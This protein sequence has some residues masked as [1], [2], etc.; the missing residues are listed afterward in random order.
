[1]L[2]PL[3]LICQSFASF[4]HVFSIDFGSSNT[5]VSTYYN[6]KVKIL[7]NENGN[8]LTPSLVAYDKND[9]IIGEN[10]QNQMILRPDKVVFSLKQF[11]GRTY[12]DTNIKNYI[13]NYPVQII[14]KDNIP[15]FDFQ[16]KYNYND[17]YKPDKLVAMIFTKMKEI[18]YQNSKTK[19]DNAVITIPSYFNE[20]QCN[21]IKKAA[22]KANIKIADIITEQEAAIL[23]YGL[24]K[25]NDTN[26][27]IIIFHLGGYTCEVSLFT[28]ENST[29]NLIE[30]QNDI[31]LGG[32]YF[33]NNIVDYLLDSFSNCTG[34]DASKDVRAIFKLKSGVEKIKHE[35]SMINKTKL[36]IEDFYDGENLIEKM[37]RNDFENINEHLFQK[38]QI[39]IKNVLKKSNCT[40]NDIDEIV[41]IGGSTKIPKVQQIISDCFKGKK[42]FK[43]INPDQV[44]AYGAGLYSTVISINSNPFKSIQI[45]PFSLF[46]DINGKIKSKI[47]PKFCSF[48]IKVTKTILFSNDNHDYLNI[49]VYVEHKEMYERNYNFLIGKFKLKATKNDTN[50]IIITFDL[51]QDYILNVTA[52]NKI[53]NK[54]IIIDNKDKSFNNFI[55]YIR[56][57]KIR[58]KDIINTLNKVG[59]E[60]KMLDMS[61]QKAL[62]WLNI[63]INENVILYDKFKND[64][65][66]HFKN[67]I[68]K[69]I[70]KA[71]YHYYW[72]DDIENPI[73][74]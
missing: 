4:S 14:D 22:K 13:N 45:N 41:L 27:K 2:I 25:N 19:M 24:N 40:Y 32:F 73:I 53:D 30:T 65:E 59:N 18:V 57:A 58:Y 15:H 49:S 54:A 9:F 64:I 11:L 26:K 20:D 44:V 7:E 37:T 21:A 66:Y 69:K 3:S 62:K 70:K 17:W 36:I 42:I 48:P 35:L 51:N 72:E 29:I 50:E 1:M 43:S 67:V 63:H 23:A 31:Y 5:C 6:G 55:S 61:R 34:K 60:I 74:F 8:Y 71:Q 39:L 68:S 33:N 47:I 16:N 46:I 38:I 28:I 12:N 52:R 10:A 56:D